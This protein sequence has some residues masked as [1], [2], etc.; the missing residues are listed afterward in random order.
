[1]TFNA[2]HLVEFLLARY[3]E[4]ADAARA[5]LGNHWH[6]QGWAELRT[7]PTDTPGW[8]LIAEGGHGFDVRPSFAHIARHDPA[9][10]LADVTAKRIIVASFME[11]DYLPAREV[12][13]SVLCDL[14]LPYA[15]HADYRQEWI[16]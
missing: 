3:T 11:T 14:A 6:A 5:A 1:M 10:V 16:T 9:R 13:L 7:E 4:D 8:A 12:L 15:D 2:R